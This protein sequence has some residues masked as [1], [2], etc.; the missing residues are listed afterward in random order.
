MAVDPPDRASEG[1]FFHS[2][3]GISRA[4]PVPS[5]GSYISDDLAA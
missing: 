3:T 4:S 5:G 2:S 1:S